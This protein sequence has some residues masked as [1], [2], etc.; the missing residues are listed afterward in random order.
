MHIVHDY[1][2]TSRIRDERRNLLTKFCGYSLLLLRGE[3]WLIRKGN[4]FNVLLNPNFS[5]SSAAWYM[6]PP[7]NE[8]NI[9]CSW[10]GVFPWVEHEKHFHSIL[11]FHTS[12]AKLVTQRMLK[13]LDTLVCNSEL[14]IYSYVFAKCKCNCK[15]K[16]GHILQCMVL[17]DERLHVQILDSQIFA[18]TTFQQRH[19]I[20]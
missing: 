17:R 2:K 4:C 14:D 12:A 5:L 16:Y 20:N 3:F 15:N 11:I 1:S 7:Y 10:Q 13:Y 18:I 8:W 19:S 6:Y 9:L